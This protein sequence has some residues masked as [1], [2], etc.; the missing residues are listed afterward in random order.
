MG[1]FGPPSPFAADQGGSKIHRQFARRTM[2]QSDVA[3]RPNV[4][5]TVMV[6]D[7]KVIFDLPTSKGIINDV[8]VD[9]E[10]GLCWDIEEMTE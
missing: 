9:E 10:T 7:T 2:S 3:H 5:H 4:K 1:G 8:D 6:G